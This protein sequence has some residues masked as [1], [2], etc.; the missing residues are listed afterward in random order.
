[1]CGRFALYASSEE[2]AE[3]L[4]CPALL[5]FQEERRYN[6][7]PGQWVIIVR[8]ERSGRAPALARWG[9]VP[10]WARDP[11]AGPRPINARA[12]G[13]AS[14]PT[15]RTALRRG[16]CLVPA[17]GYFEWKTEGRAKTPYFIR[18]RGGGILLFAGLADTWHGPEGE[19]ATCALVTTAPNAAMAELHDRMPAILD[20]RAAQAWLDPACR[21]PEDL[22]EPCAPDLLEAWPVGPAVGNPRNDSPAL[23]EPLV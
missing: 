6:I 22:L 5:G 14:K 7:A 12:E 17:S 16:R 18:P 13:L 11:E 3:A 2:L 21:N 19:L 23:V 9:L 15:F 4:G 1:M 10:G 20:S 8:P